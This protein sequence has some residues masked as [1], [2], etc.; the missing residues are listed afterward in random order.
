M[1]DAETFLQWGR[2]PDEFARLANERCAGH[3][4][5]DELEWIA[6]P[7]GQVKLVTRPEWRKRF[8]DREDAA[9]EADRKKFLWRQEHPA[10]EQELGL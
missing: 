5:A 1:A 3:P 8:R 4:R 10:D 2:T 6:T 9:R 7:N